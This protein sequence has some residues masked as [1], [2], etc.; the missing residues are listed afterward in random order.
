MMVFG[1]ADLIAQLGYLSS[2]LS[3]VQLLFSNLNPLQ[4]TSI[5]V[6]PLGKKYQLQPTSTYFNTL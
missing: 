3:V 1:E 5:Y 2:V 6:N 4:P